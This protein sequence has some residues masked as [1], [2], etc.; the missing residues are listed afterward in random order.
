M[1]ILLVYNGIN[2]NEYALK[3]LLEHQE[4]KGKYEKLDSIIGIKPILNKYFKA[5]KRVDGNSHY[6]LIVEVQTEK[7]FDSAVLNFFQKFWLIGVPLIWWDKLGDYLKAITNERLMNGIKHCVKELVTALKDK[8]TDVEIDCVAHSL[9]TL[10]ALDSE[11][12]FEKVFLMGS[13]L[14]SR[15][16]SIRTTATNFIRKRKA[17]TSVANVWYFYSKKD[18]VCTKLLRADGYGLWNIECNCS[19]AIEGYIDEAVKKGLLKG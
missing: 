8:Y 14:T 9:G 3:S 10:I 12:R 4:F 5:Y 11:A 7:F 17:P 16:W 15:L 2:A 1:K 13:P 6:D 18:I 19:H